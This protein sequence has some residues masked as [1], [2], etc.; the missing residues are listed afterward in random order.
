M[1][2][3]LLICLT[4]IIF[5]TGGNAIA[6]EN[7]TESRENFS[8]N[9][10]H[11]IQ[12]PVRDNPDNF[13]VQFGWPRSL[14]GSEAMWG[15][16][17]TVMDFDGFGDWELA[18]L[19]TENRLHAFQHDAANVPGFPI[20]THLGNRPRSWVNPRHNATTAAGDFS[21]D[22]VT[23][24]VYITDIGYLHVVREDE[25]EPQ[26]F[27]ID[28]GLN[29]N[30]GVP[31]LSDFD[32]DGELEIIF[33]SYSSH[34]DSMNS[35]ALLHV[36]KRNGEELEN[37]PVFFPRGS[38]SSPV[39]GDIDNDGNPEIVIGNSRY[40][41]ESAQIWAWKVD[42]SLVDG[43]PFGHFHTIGGSPTLADI[44]GDGDLNILFWA[45]DADQNTAGVYV[46]NG[47][48]ETI[49]GFPVE[50]IPG[51]PE[52]NPVVADINGDESPEIVFGTFNPVTGGCIYAW[53]CTGDLLDSFP[54]QLD[55]SVIGSVL[56]ADM[57]GDG[58]TDIVAALSPVEGNHG[59]ISAWGSDSN[60][61]EGFPISLGDYGG[62]V[63]SAT[64][65]I[66]DIDRDWDLDLMAV[67]TDRRLFIWDTPGQ[68]TR[69]VWLTYKAD[70][71]RSGIRPADNPLS[72]PIVVDKPVIPSKI[73][74]EAFPNPFN[75]SA[76]IIFRASRV[77]F[78]KIDLIDQAGRLI[79]QLQSKETVPGEFETVIDSQALSLAAGLYFCRITNGSSVFVTRLLYMP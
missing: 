42:G 50:C 48:G 34:Q 2:N 27:P 38:G 55:N 37:W 31:V 59:L 11:D 77:D 62:G 40:L 16:S 18:I 61:L 25:T 64:P 19:N 49:D 28:I 15:Q 17:I 57:S 1:K 7:A 46:L 73:Q 9:L 75:S 47:N 6:F 32:G 10:M 39:S 76:R 8:F 78:R 52:G 45:A 13:D 44:N 53:T 56:L 69:D 63:I 68:V 79:S 3:K 51:H 36:I 54:L 20:R 74:F 65:T 22:G 29:A 43:F 71:H 5:L 58:I 67:T 12:G 72:S 66:W 60:V 14:T 33:S 30:S 4:A 21:G 35:N 41:D 70:M 23:D 24:L 26:P